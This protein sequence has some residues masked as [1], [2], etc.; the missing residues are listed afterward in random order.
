MAHENEKF[1]GANFASE[2]NGGVVVLT[3]GWQEFDFGFM[4]EDI[5]IMNDDGTYW[6]EYAWELNANGV[7]YEPKRL[8]AGEVKNYEKT[9][10]RRNK[11]YLR[12]QTGGVAFRVHVN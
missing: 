7:A 2:G 4:S 6:L 1:R 11:I 8:L 5:D 12:A 3:T 10:V 9:D